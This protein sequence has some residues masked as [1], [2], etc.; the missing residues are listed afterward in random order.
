MKLNPDS[1]V[2]H[3]NLARILHTQ[4]RFGEAIEHYSAA[5]RTDPKL[6]Q[7]HNNLGIL[8]VQKGRLAEGVV[9][10]REASKLNPEN[11]ET[12]YNLAMA[13]NQQEQWS[14]AAELFAKTVAGSSTDPNAHYQF[15]VALVHLH[16]TREAMSHYASALLLQPDFPDALDGLAWILATAATPEFRNGPEAIRM[17]ERACELTGRRDSARL[18]TLAAAYAEAGRFP[19]AIATAQT[20]LGLAAAADRKESA[21]DLE[22]MLTSFKAAKPWRATMP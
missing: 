14:E 18:K 16:K 2:A 12:Q 22:A 17:A 21:K 9:E 10:L 15:A 8:L 6:A 4:S 1:A 3:N 7:A 13:L 19:E 20:T 5:L 11:P